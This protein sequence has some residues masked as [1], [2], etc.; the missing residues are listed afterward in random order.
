MSQTILCVPTMNGV[1]ELGSTD[2]VSF[3]IL[4]NFKIFLEQFIFIHKFDVTIPSKVP[5]LLPIPGLLRC[6]LSDVA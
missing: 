1:V 3:Y 5:F 6:L 4:V 2:L